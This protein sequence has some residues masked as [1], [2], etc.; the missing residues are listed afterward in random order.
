ML[1]ATGAT[2]AGDFSFREKRYAPLKILAVVKTL[3]PMGVDARALLA[4]SGLTTGEIANAHTRTSVNQYLT[5]CRNAARLSPEP[6][7]AIA[8]G[9][10]MR[11]T[12]YGMYGYALACADSLR[13]ATELAVRYHLLATPVMRI[14][15]V[16]DEAK[17]AW[18]FPGMHEVELPDAD[19]EL[20]RSLLE[21]QVLVHMTMTRDVMGTWCMPA[22]AR[23]ALPRPAYAQR[24]ESSL[25]CPIEF[26]QHHTELHYPLEWLERTPQFANPITAQ[27]VSA[28]C[29]R[30]LEEHKWGSG[31]TRRVYQELMRTPGR[32]P[33]IDE[34]ARSLC[35]ASRTMRRK[36]DEEGTSYSGLLSSV[37]CALAVDY[38]S[39]SLLEVE[40]IASALGFSDVAGFRHAFKR[41][42]G[43]TPSQYRQN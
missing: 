33:D 35:M 5:V 40:D 43:K 32:F 37:R 41:W 8:V 39:T 9:S 15:L 38:L 14:R 20:F 12:A 21:I 25:E 22:R 7:W 42:T 31:L 6:G 30:L 13:R 26:D 27:Q 24:L 10:Q 3:V 2:T 18:M 34:V 11:L 19:A 23:F 28:T 36:L 4:G 16:E 1:K 17:A 29:E